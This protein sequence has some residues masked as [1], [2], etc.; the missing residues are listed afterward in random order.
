MET[1]NPLIFFF[2][3]LEVT[4]GKE[5]ISKKLVGK[6]FVDEVL[7]TGRLFPLVASFQFSITAGCLLDSCVYG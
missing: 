4:S 7:K 5:W 2:Y 3:L 6:A 1:P